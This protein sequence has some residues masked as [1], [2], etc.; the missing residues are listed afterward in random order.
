MYRDVMIQPPIEL[1]KKRLRE[2][3]YYTTKIFIYIR[4][5]WE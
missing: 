4:T 5:E 3:T 1:V 2:K